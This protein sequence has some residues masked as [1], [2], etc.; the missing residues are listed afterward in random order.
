MPL[1]E[2]TAATTMESF[3]SPNQTFLFKVLCSFIKLFEK[4]SG[5]SNAI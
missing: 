3:V 5:Y 4:G 1:V 2:T